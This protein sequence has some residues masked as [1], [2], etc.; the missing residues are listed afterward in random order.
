MEFLLTVIGVV[1]VVEGIPWFLSPQR[2]KSLL[3]QI[4]AT[5]DHILRI[6]GFT[7]MALGLLVVFFAV[8]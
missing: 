2:V 7:L 4:M 8:G 3:Q 6:L 1:M 5:S